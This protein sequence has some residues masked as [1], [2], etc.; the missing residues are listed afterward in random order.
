MNKKIFLIIAIFLVGIFMPKVVFAEEFEQ[1]LYIED[2]TGEHNLLEGD[3]V[4]NVTYDSETN[5]LTLNNFELSNNIT[6]F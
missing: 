2:A 4:E 5:T 1:A 3:E 6:F